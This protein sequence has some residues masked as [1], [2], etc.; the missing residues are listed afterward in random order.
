[1]FVSDNIIIVNCADFVNTE[2]EINGEFSEKM[3]FMDEKCRTWVKE[4]FFMIV[5]H[6]AVVI[7]FC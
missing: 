7:F 5:L 1:M 2:L 3:V 4:G 6:G